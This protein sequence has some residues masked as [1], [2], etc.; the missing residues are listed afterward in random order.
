MTNIRT[1]KRKKC[2]D[3]EDQ[4]GINRNAD[5]GPSCGGVFTNSLYGWNSEQD[6]P[7]VT[8]PIESNI[9]YNPCKL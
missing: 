4:H 8:N 5:L 2:E 6:G 7:V 9:N 1:R 3:E